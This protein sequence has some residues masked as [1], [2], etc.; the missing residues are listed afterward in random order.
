VRRVH[1]WARACRVVL[2]DGEQDRPVALVV[3]ALAEQRQRAAGVAELAPPIVVHALPQA[4][5]A[6]HHL[7][8]PCSSFFDFSRL[9][10]RFATV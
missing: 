1:D 8:R 2:R 6:V 5:V 7:V 4:I 10:P 9:R 3:A